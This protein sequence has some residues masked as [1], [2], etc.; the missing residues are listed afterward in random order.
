MYTISSNGFRE[1][2][3]YDDDGRTV[4]VATVAGDHSWRDAVKADIRR[5][6]DRNGSP[7]QYVSDHGN[8]IPVRRVTLRSL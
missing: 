5:Y 1:T 2:V 3:S 7:C 6:P 4:F 8:V